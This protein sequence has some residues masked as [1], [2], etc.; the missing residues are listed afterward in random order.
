MSGT[1]VPLSSILSPVSLAACTR[2]D[3]IFCPH[4][5]PLFSVALHLEQ[6]QLTLFHQVTAGIPNTVTTYDRYKIISSNQSREAQELFRI[7]VDNGRLFLRQMRHS[8]T[9]L[10]VYKYIDTTVDVHV[11]TSVHGYKLP[12]SLTGITEYYEV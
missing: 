11:I 5:I 12:D 8:S 7:S 3:S 9:L 2:I 1:S 6:F 10:K 4:F